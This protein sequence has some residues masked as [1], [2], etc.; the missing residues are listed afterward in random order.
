MSRMEFWIGLLAS[1][2]SI[3]IGVIAGFL[4]H[5]F[6]VGL[7]CAVVVFI[8]VVFGGDWYWKTISEKRS[9]KEA[10]VRREISQQQS[11]LRGDA[12]KPTERQTTPEGVAVRKEPEKPDEALAK[13]ETKTILSGAKS[14]LTTRECIM[15]CTQCGQALR[16]GVKFCEKCGAKVREYAPESAASTEKE[17]LCGNCGCAVTSNS[18]TCKWCGADLK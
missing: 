3:V 11:N 12:T 16:D 6:V 17:K 1:G 10:Q 4:T 15:L 5:E 8:A 18:E 9:R 13:C 7:A 14:T 2:L